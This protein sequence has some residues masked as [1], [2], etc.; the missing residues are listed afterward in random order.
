MRVLCRTVRT[1]VFR[2]AFFLGEPNTKEA[3]AEIDVYVTF[4]S[5]IELVQPWQVVAQACA[6]SG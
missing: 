4:C 6:G 1:H 5:C 2:T 3:C